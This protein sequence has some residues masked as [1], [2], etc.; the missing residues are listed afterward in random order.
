M[1][2]KVQQVITYDLNANLDDDRHHHNVD[3]EFNKQNNENIDLSTNSP[4]AIMKSKVVGSSSTT[5]TSTAA[6]TTASITN[7][8]TSIA[9]PN[10]DEANSIISNTLSNTISNV[11]SPA[12]AAVM[13]ATPIAVSYPLLQLALL[14]T[15]AIGTSPLYFIM[16]TFLGKSNKSDNL[17][18]IEMIKPH[19]R[20]QPSIVGSI[21]NPSNQASSSSPNNSV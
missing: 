12:M 16:I 8:C 17:T 21:G 14:L 9:T 7:S 2:P 20:R 6:A 11:M 19:H 4:M 3:K 10:Q 1:A 13:I 5:T 15:F 18:S